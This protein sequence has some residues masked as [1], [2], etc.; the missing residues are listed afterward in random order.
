MK[1]LYV[2]C[3]VRVANVS[4][5]WEKAAGRIGRITQMGVETNDSDAK[6]RVEGAIVMFSGQCGVRAPYWALEPII[7]P[8]L[9]QVISW[10]DMAG[11]WTPSGV[12]A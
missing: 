5:A 11:L 4:G 1:R 10:A 7:D 8:D 6:T 12:E 3:R 2:G 9:N